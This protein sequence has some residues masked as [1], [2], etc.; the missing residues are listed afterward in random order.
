MLNETP[1]TYIVTLFRVESATKH[2]IPFACVGLGPMRG[3]ELKSY[4]AVIESHKKSDVGDNTNH[5]A[6]CD[7]RARRKSRSKSAQI[8]TGFC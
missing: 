5:T 3:R 1:K 6:A 4:A 2:H 8:E 7:Y